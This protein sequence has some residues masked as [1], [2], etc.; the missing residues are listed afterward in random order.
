MRK[1]RSS[2]KVEI[3][4]IG[5]LLRVAWWGNYFLLCTKETAFFPY[6]YH[7]IIFYSTE[8]FDC[9]V[10][11]K[12]YLNFFTFFNINKNQTLKEAIFELRSSHLFRDQPYKDRY[13]KRLRY[14]LQ[15]SDHRVLQFSGFASNMFLFF[16]SK[17]S[18]RPVISQV[19]YPLRVFLSDFGHIFPTCFCRTSHNLICN[20]FA[21][22]KNKKLNKILEIGKF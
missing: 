5:F 21:I 22:L 18:V 20:K 6:F 16:G 17:V 7:E 15:H 4:Q 9:A 13:C 8:R 14:H 11:F 2:E 12:F 19:F 1:L 10:N 3:L